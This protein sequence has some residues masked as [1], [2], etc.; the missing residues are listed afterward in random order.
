MQFLLNRSY[1]LH[2]KSLFILICANVYIRFCSNATS[3]TQ[4][5]VHMASVRASMDTAEC[6]AAVFTALTSK[7][8]VVRPPVSLDEV[9]VALQ[10]LQYRLLH[11]PKNIY[12][13]KFQTYYCDS[14]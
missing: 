2:N 5:G 11:L 12:N 9:F 4:R 8:S 3:V 14:C 13:N 1:S 6:D 10:V 7:Q